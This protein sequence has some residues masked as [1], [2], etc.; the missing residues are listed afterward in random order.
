M[1]GSLG[2]PSLSP[3]AVKPNTEQQA[4]ST[5]TPSP[6]SLPSGHPKLKGALGRGNYRCKKGSVVLLAVG[7]INKGGSLGTGRKGR[8]EVGSIMQNF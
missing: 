3:K 7:G 2:Q 8:R 5:L 1:F 4:A 6:G